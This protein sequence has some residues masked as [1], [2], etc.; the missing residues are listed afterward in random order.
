[1]FGVK[2]LCQRST[3]RELAQIDPSVMQG[4]GFA[5]SYTKV[6]VQVALSSTLSRSYVQNRY[7]SPLE[8][9]ANPGGPLFYW[10]HRHPG[11]ALGRGVR[12]WRQSA[13]R[14]RPISA[15]ISLKRISSLCDA[16]FASQ[17]C[18]LFAKG[19]E[20]E[21]PCA[22][23]FSHSPCWSRQAALR[24]ATA[25]QN[26]ALSA[27]VPGRPSLPRPGANRSP[28]RLSAVWQA[29]SATTSGCATN[30][31]AYRPKSHESQGALGRSGFFYAQTAPARALNLG[32][33]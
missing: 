2:L 31:P 20:G 8:R 5:R 23:H 9:F 13:D 16:A 10:R 7:P 17:T 18:F 29:S 19:K 3:R 24:P 14:R 27:P 15:G 30:K 22:T 12:A 26:A 6:H 33:R 32:T 28:V 4:L 21:Q 1:M 11:H 25:M